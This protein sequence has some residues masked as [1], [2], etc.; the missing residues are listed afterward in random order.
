MTSARDRTSTG[1]PGSGRTAPLDRPG[2]GGQLVTSAVVNLAHATEQK[3][4]M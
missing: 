1:P 2:C 3:M 4:T